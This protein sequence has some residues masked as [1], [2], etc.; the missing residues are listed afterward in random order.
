[1]PLGGF[2]KMFEKML[3]HKNITILLNSDFFDI[4]DKIKFD[5]LIF[6]GRID[7]FFNYKFGKL[8]YRCINFTFETLNK[9]SFQP[10]SV[11]NH[12]GKDVKFLRVTE[13]KKFYNNNCEKTVLCKEIFD[14]NSELSYPVLTER[15][16]KLLE[17]YKKE[18]EKLKN[19]LLIGRLAQYKYFNMDQAVEEALDIFEK[20]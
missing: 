2:G 1:M 13:F 16:L 14:W 10:N 5:K 17:E 3:N 9:E 18:A 4:K 19:V 6:T 7:Q 11:V 12:T 20:F 15:N 8:D